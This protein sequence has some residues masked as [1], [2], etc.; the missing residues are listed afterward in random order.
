MPTIRFYPFDVTY[1]EVNDRPL[2]YLFGTT[3]K[4]D[5]VCVI[6]NK[7]RPYFYAVL[8]NPS[9]NEK[10]IKK[11]KK[12]KIGKA[13]LHA[14]VTGAEEVKKKYL[15]Q[16][17]NAVKVYSNLPRAVPVLREEIRGYAEVKG[18]YEADILYARRYLIDKGIIP[19]N[20][21]SAEGD[22]INQKSRVSVFRA[23]KIGPQ[24]EEA[25]TDLR[26]LSFDIETYSPVGRD[27][28]PEKNPMLMV[29]FYGERFRK[30]ITWKR[31]RT[32]HDYIE[33]VASEAELIKRFKEV[34]DTYKPDI[35]TGYY[36]DG[37]DLPYISTRAKHHK[38]KLDIGLD[39]SELKLGRGKIPS[40][41]ISGITHLDILSFIRRVLSRSL[42]TD[43]YGLGDVASELLGEK[44]IEVDLDE[45]SNAWDNNKKELERFCEYNLK[46]SELTYKL[47]RK[48]LPNIIELV[49]IIG[50]TAFDITRMGFSQLVEWYITR[51]A[52]RFNEIAPNKPGYEETRKRTMQSF[53]GAFVYEPSP[54][55]YD[56]IVVFDY[57]SLYPTIISSHNIG[58][59][60]LNCSCCREGA[61]YAPQEKGQKDKYWFCA[62]KKGF[63]STV[64]AD[65]ITR[66][67]RIKEIIK[68][69]KEKGVL[70]Q[71]RS[72]ALKLL[73]NSFYGYLGFFGARWYSLESAKSV[74]A[75]GRY[76]IH[77]VIDEAKKSGF[78]VLY[79]DTDS[80]FLTLDSKNKSD[81]MNFA[82][83]VNMELPGLMELEYEGFYPRGM[84]VSIKE[85]SYGAKKKYALLTEEKQVKIRGFETIRRN[86]SFI[87]KDV[88]AE[89]LRIILND[90][91]PENAF[92]YVKDMI[93][94]LREKKI[95]IEKVVI[96]T[97]LQKNIDDYDAIGPHV[98]V[99]MRMRNQG[100]EVGPGSIIKFVVTKGSGK[101]RDRARLVSEV[102]KNEYDP[103]Y[104]INNQI[105]PSVD[106][107]FEI[108]GISKEQLLEKKEQ[109]T[110]GSF[111]GK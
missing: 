72:E 100:I 68:E 108:F 101:I 13:G 61:N 86:W 82:E 2:V 29:A 94:K 18:V 12:V 33:F 48:I 40:A 56:N 27:I 104:Y 96:Y 3:D 59:G 9:H 105:I 70:L 80:V 79:S 110:L 102:K 74:T 24:T 17:V 10:F 57:R 54:G 7:F 69:K 67:M 22:F 93:H 88:Q 23:D 42:Q 15:G 95:P 71:A 77:K 63:L 47:C 19:F 8:K 28:L 78:K 91:K 97:Q 34:I 11:I 84:F 83:K 35:L 106:K 5:R 75:Y 65:I 55:L 98:A 60:T 38:I 20:L 37:F 73:A 45:L 50:L 52:P 26:I 103:D 16:D 14:E 25:K 39:Y 66:R 44:K 58:P 76:Y 21:T 64:I 111:M 90:G 62:K 6:D 46:D 4:G 89:V 43:T 32:K 109:S 99:A 87:A 107:I 51:Q 41:Q 81:A 30:V 49:R 53:K 31:F 1:R 36:S 92:K 85:G